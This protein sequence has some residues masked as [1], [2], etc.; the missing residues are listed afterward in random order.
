MA[1]LVQ[2][3]QRFCS[4]TGLDV[5]SAVMS[6][7]DDQIKQIVALLN[8]GVVELGNK[9]PWSRLQFLTTFLST[10]D[11]SQGKIEDIAPGFQK[12][13]SD[14]LWSVSNRLPGRGGITPADS[15]ALRIWGRPNALVNFRLMDGELHFLPPGAAGLS[16]SFEYQSRFC[17]YD[18]D[19]HE[20]KEFFTKDTDYTVLPDMLYIFDLRWRWKMEKMLAYSEHLRSF[21]TL[22]KQTYSNQLGALPV[23]MDQPH[24]AVLPGIVVPLGNWNKP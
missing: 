10:G 3:V 9:Y 14:T 24:G 6:S 22:A 18:G 13:L 11:E 1:T 21:E 23:R 8:E 4:S 12:M 20:L 17:V 16:Y 7:G 15:Q 5:P 2:I 19:T